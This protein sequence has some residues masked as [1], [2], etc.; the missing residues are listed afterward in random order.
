VILSP[1]PTGTPAD[2]SSSTKPERQAEYLAIFEV[3]KLSDEE[4]EAI[5]EAGRG[6][7]YKE[8]A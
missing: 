1:Q 2:F 7:S 8:W 4:V 3:D 6:R 5:T